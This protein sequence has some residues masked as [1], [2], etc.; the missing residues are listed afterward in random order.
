MVPDPA[1]PTQTNIMR[2]SNAIAT[3]TVPSANPNMVYVLSNQPQPTQASIMQA[4]GDNNFLTEEDVEMN[5][6][7][8]VP[9]SAVVTSL[10]TVSS[11]QRATNEKI[12]DLRNELL[13][14]KQQM[15][16]LTNVVT[17]AM[18]VLKKG[19]MI[20]QDNPASGLTAKEQKW[21]EETFPITSTEN[22]LKF[23]K[24]LEY[25]DEMDKMKKYFTKY[26]GDAGN[27]NGIACARKLIDLIVQ[28]DVM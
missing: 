25:P 6:S 27:K 14:M 12:D 22:L 15:H 21:F 19:G 13:G 20:K 11:E 7:A 10:N 1:Q 17:E 5:F 16:Q 28:R 18:A 9:N 26:Y 24:R 4:S 3:P 8:L 23:N 2:T